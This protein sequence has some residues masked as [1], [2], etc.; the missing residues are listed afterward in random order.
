M[1][2]FTTD[3]LIAE[4]YDHW[5]LKAHADGVQDHN[6]IRDSIIAKLRAADALCEAA[7]VAVLDCEYCS[8]NLRKAIREYEEAGS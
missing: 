7:K 8:E 3:E 2:K 6:N 4:I 5:K 1:S